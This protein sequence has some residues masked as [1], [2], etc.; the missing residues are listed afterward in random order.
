MS[1][2]CCFLQKKLWMVVFKKIVANKCKIHSPPIYLFL[3]WKE[4][5][6][7]FISTSYVFIQICSNELKMLLTHIFEWNYFHALDLF[8]WMFWSWLKWHKNYGFKCH[9]FCKE[10]W[11]RI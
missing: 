6:I 7:V 8:K 11:L 1:S 9:A 3:N 10:L 4:K 5:N 2:P